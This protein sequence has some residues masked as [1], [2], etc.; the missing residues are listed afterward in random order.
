MIVFG[1]L[2]YVGQ[3]IFA[4]N[5]SIVHLPDILSDNY[6]KWV[7]YICPLIRCGDFY[8]GCCAGYAYK[9]RKEHNTSKRFATVTEILSIAFIVVSNVIYSRR[10]GFIGSECFRYSLLFTPSSVMLIYIFAMEEG[11]ISKLLA[12]K[13]LVWLGDLTAYAFLIH[14]IAIRF[15][16]VVFHRFYSIIL[17][18]WIIVFWGFVVT[19]IST[20]IWLRMV[21]PWINRH[22][23]FFYH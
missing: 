9:N 7:M 2:I 5:S 13:P 1:I 18:P 15:V 23:H 8:I 16:T 20:I 6:S 10:M 14:P 3:I 22:F 17:N 19:V 12:N 4:I 11:V 21:S